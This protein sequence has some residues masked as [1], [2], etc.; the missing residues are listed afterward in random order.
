MADKLQ[1]ALEAVIPMNAAS[2]HGGS[3]S[4]PNCISSSMTYELSWKA[5]VWRTIMMSRLSAVKLAT[6]SLLLTGLA[7]GASAHALLQK[8]VPAVGGTVRTSPTEI[9]LMF[10]EGVEIS[11]SGINLRSESGAV[12][13]GKASVAPGDNS[14]LVASVPK[15][16]K[17]GVYTVSWHCVSIDTHKTQ[18]TFQF[19]VKP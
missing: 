4:W 15:A 9:R 19:T 16:L 11:F 7:S 17:P 12:P 13:L 3:A 5:P 1:F 2:G 8:A 6:V 14:T 10:S 18:G